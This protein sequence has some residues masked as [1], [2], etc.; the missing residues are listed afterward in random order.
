MSGM[1][2]TTRL[3]VLL[4]ACISATLL[5]TTT[6]DYQVSKRRILSQVSA[7]TEATVVAALHSAAFA[8][9]SL[10][11]A[12]FALSERVGSGHRYRAAN[13][14]RYSDYHSYVSHVFLE[15]KSIIGSTAADRPHSLYI[16]T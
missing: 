5:V 6:I 4:T 3:V 2:L 7:N 10:E 13:C 12:A 11:A 14:Q 16:P 9:A 8:S 1:S 15:Q